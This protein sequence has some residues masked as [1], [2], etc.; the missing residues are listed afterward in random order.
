[1]DTGFFLQYGLGGLAVAVVTAIATEFIK[2]PIKDK[3]IAKAEQ[4]GIDK[5]V[6][7]KWLAVIPL[8]LAFIGSV[9]NVSG[10]T[11][12]SNP[13]VAS[14]FDWKMAV[15]ETVACWGVATAFYE[16]GSNIFKSVTSKQDAKATSVAIPTAP[17]TANEKRTERL[18]ERLA[19]A[20]AAVVAEESARIN[21]EQA[22]A[23]AKAKA[24]AKADAY[25][26]IKAEALQ[27]AKIEAKANEIVK[28]KTQ[29]E[30]V[31]AQR[32]TL[33]AKLKDNGGNSSIR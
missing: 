27:Q 5:S 21:K 15:T 32:A 3:M 7:T 13:F 24:Q 23:E 16:N 20:Q 18:A 22:V 1:M 10:A 6:F 12:W 25:A 30:Q 19:N 4:L 2:S 11:G 31:E 33:L 29:L 17:K 26:K 28:T 14:A 9:I 8:F